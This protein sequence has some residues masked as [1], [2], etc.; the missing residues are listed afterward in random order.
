MRQSAH[1]CIGGLMILALA[2]TV[3]LSGCP[4]KAATLT[5]LISGNAAEA[6]DSK[7]SEVGLD[8]I[9]RLEVTVTEVSVDY[10]G[11]A[12]GEGEGEGEGDDDSGKLVLFSGEKRIDIRQLQG[13]SEVLS[14]ANLRPGYYT[15]VRLSVKDPELVLTADPGTVI[16]D[17]Q[18]TANSRLFVSTAFEL[19][20]GESSLLLL[21]FDDIHLVQTGSG[22]Y[23]W[24]PQLRA[25]VSVVPAAITA[26]GVIDSIDTTNQIFL[27]NVEDSDSVLQVRYDGAAV[28]LPGDTAAPSGSFSDLGAG[29]H[30]EV[31]GTLDVFG[32]VQAVQIHVAS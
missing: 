12:P 15:K 14:T 27:L 2:G 24:T 18:L 1:C 13:I 23:V 31:T 7:S 28:F 9:Q 32:E 30:V 21:D 10:A 4:P 3:L 26:G 8:E 16:T 22:K 29:V 17:V 6:S 5:V 11:G 20:A 19:P 25:D